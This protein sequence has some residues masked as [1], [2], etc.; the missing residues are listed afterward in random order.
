MNS[1]SY[2][3]HSLTALRVYALGILLTLSFL[4]RAADPG[5]A[6]ASPAPTVHLPQPIAWAEPGTQATAPCSGD[7]LAVFADEQ[8]Q[9]RLR[10][11]PQ[12]L[13]GEVTREGLWLTS[14]V[15]GS[16]AARFRV[17]AGSLGREGGKLRPLPGSGVVGAEAGRVC[18]MRRGVTEEYSVSADGVRQDFVVAQPPGGTGN[19]RVELTLTGTRAEATAESA[20]LVLDGSG[21][22]L[23]YSRL[24]VM[25]AEERQLTA[26]LEVVSDRRLAVVVAD[27][28]AV[29]PVR[30][31]PTFSDANWV[32]LGRG[33][34][35]GSPEVYAAV[36]D[37]AGNLYCGGG[38]QMAGSA[39]VN[40]IAK[41]NG[42]AWSALGSGITGLGTP[43]FALAVSGTDLYAAGGITTAGEVSVNNIARWDG[44]AWSALGSGMNSFV[45]ALAVFGTNLYAGGDFT[46][47][48]GRDAHYVAKWDGTAWSP[49]GSGMNNYVGALAVSGT[50]LYA[51]GRFTTAGG[52]NANHVAK[53][54]GTAW[55]PL[56]SWTNGAVAVLAVSGTDLY[57]AGFL[58][59]ERGINATYC[60]AKWDGNAWSALATEIRRGVYALAA[61]GTD[62]YAGGNFTAVGGV[63]ANYI[64]KWDGMAWSPL[65]SGMNNYVRALAVSGTDLYAGGRFTTA[66]GKACYFVAK[67]LLLRFGANNATYT[68]TPGASLTIRIA[69]VAW[70]MNGNPVTVQSLGASSHGATLSH[71]NTNIYYQPASDSNDSFTFTVSNGFETATGT[72]T[73][74]VTRPPNTAPVA[75]PDIYT[76]PKDHSLSGNVIN[77]NT[78]S[79]VDSDA[80][81]DPLTAH[82]DA[83]PAHAQTFSLN[84]DGSFVYTPQADFTGADAFT[85]HVN[86]GQADS[87]MVTV[88][89]TVT[90]VNDAPSF[91]KGADQTVME[92]A[93]PQAIASWASGLRAGPA[94]EA[95]QTLTFVASVDQPALFAAGPGIAADG[96]LTYTPAP[97]ASGAATVT[98]TLN[99]DG[100]TANGGAD[101]SLPQTFT[102]TV[103]GLQPPIVLTAITLS[104]VTFKFSWNAQAGQSYR[105]QYKARLEDAEWIDVGS[106]IV[107]T[108][109]TASAED[110]VNGG[111]QRFYR[112]LLEN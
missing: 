110:T 19:L 65:G 46:T 28:V 24:R 103:K 34:I 109:A 108:G 95:G 27:A 15:P 32:N 7:G 90:A 17:V 36:V 23:A 40:H 29:Y 1:T 82:V 104:G 84:A 47:A 6:L 73:V 107:A 14:T 58:T 75:T 18:Y 25:D 12:Q 93:G 102:I 3:L 43:V 31:D 21:R 33:F 50:D 57:A 89:I 100:G 55:S 70:D 101:T 52:V 97:N 60:V 71:D 85:Y 37:G 74:T 68:R 88:T 76:V 42:S 45:Y 13:E 72:I 86:D 9:V 2:A 61:S 11:T 44:K 78:G 48:G 87:P 69:D 83:S 4:L 16:A 20:C 38:F 80:D 22:K 91:V 79:G 112:V 111:E 99:D 81:R 105:V 10:C 5:S 35:G 67:A 26:R 30:I 59:E 77:D 53:W 41:W 54:D 56:G 94:D 98:V 63:N 92:D 66:G 62:L 49:L 39:W 8:G 96:T 51:G 106:P 64:A